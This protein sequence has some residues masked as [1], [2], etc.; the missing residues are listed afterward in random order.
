MISSNRS[1]FDDA[2]LDAK[3]FYNSAFDLS[4]IR[5]KQIE[6]KDSDQE[7]LRSGEK[8]LPRQ[9]GSI[10][11]S[12]G[13]HLRSQKLGRN[14][15]DS[16]AL[17]FAQPR[18]KGVVATAMERSSEN[19]DNFTLWVAGNSVEDCPVLDLEQE[20]MHW[21]TTRELHKI[22][23]S[24]YHIDEPNLENHLWNSILQ[25]CYP[26]ICITLEKVYYI[27]LEKGPELENIQTWIQGGVDSVQSHDITYQED[28]LNTLQFIL[29]QLDAFFLKGLNP[30]IGVAQRWKND[31]YTIMKFLDTITMQCFL[32]LESYE[33]PMRELF[34]HCLKNLHEE[35]RLWLKIIRR[36]IYVMASY[37]QA[38]YD[39]VRFKRTYSSAT[40][41]IECIPKSGY[42]TSNPVILA[43]RFKEDAETEIYQREEEEMFNRGFSHL[44]LPKESAEHRPLVHC[45][46]R[47]L[48]FLLRTPNP[49]DF[50]NYIG[51]SKG[52]CWL[53]YHTL[54]YMAPEIGMRAPHWKLYPAWGPPRFQ[55]SSHHRE[56]FIEILLFLDK[57]IKDLLN[58][59]GNSPQETHRYSGCE[60]D[61]PDVEYRFLS[62]RTQSMHWLG[63]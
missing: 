9:I 30:K 19:P 14:L 62:P 45:E 60:S 24:G 8:I 27:K 46:M 22:F 63:Q 39:M 20:I 11:E 3:S 29:D 26:S 54:K 15:L 55:E 12:G 47:I 61:C 2:L 16:F 10:I 23:S 38:W 58:S 36:L 40:L 59:A 7:L 33:E 4:A 51:C 6:I 42:S 21:F 43:D 32:L 37:C 1:I 18:A 57:R 44:Q 34:K 50:F 31:N 48:D 49:N 5:V 41:Y 56:H 17:I 52:P 25:N 35:G 53:C 28:V 13:G